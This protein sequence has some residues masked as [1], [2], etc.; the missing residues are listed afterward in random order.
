MFQLASSSCLSSAIWLLFLN[1]TSNLDDFL[2]DTNIP[3]NCEF[4]VAQK[5]SDNVVILTEVYR[6]MASLPLQTYRFGHWTV[7]G[8]LIPAPVGLYQRRNRLS[9][10]VLKTAVKKV[11]CT[12]NIRKL[13]DIFFQF[14]LQN[15]VQAGNVVMTRK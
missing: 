15:S 11:R 2:A 1:T 10:A 7:Y 12:F 8:G 3:F 4:L 9:G 5:A 13:F 14:Y 6:V